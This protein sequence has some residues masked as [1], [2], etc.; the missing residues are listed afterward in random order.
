MNSKTFYISQ[1]FK[2]I[3]YYSHQDQNIRI[4]TQRVSNIFATQI[5]TARPFFFFFFF[6]FFFTSNKRSMLVMAVH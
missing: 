6:F 1:S 3:H 4:T 5:M 2:F